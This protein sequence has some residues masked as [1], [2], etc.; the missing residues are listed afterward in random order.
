MSSAADTF[1][2]FVD[3]LIASLDDHAVSG[4]ELAARAHLS[5]FHFDRIVSAV[6]GE[7]PAALRRRILLERAAYRL[8]T[9]GDDVLPVA[10][11]AG[12]AS[13]EAFTRA[14]SRAYGT[15]PSRWRRTPGRFQL[16][17][18][19]T[20]HFDPPG[21]LRVPTQRKVTAMDVLTRMVE[22]HVWMVG[23][24]LSR[25]ERLGDARLDEP[26]TISVEG[27]DDDPTARRLLS[28]LVGQ[29]EMWDA[30]IHGRRYDF[31]VESDESVASMR[32]RL[33]QAGPAFLADVRS[34]V[35]EG[36]LDD[37]FI[38]ATCEPPETFTYAGMIAHVL[39]FGA[40]RRTLVCGVLADAGMGDLGAGDPMH[41]VAEHV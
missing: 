25:A 12:Y 29:L 23:E 4:R 11:E 7:P 28:R 20:V 13:H 27:I 14:F 35:E 40:H 17:P 33:A 41:W 32:A 36:R 26:V 6:A 8:L 2:R 39:T 3:L 34:I 15:S 21:R 19:S 18:A 22:H 1:A 38:D 5:R 31:A 37:T 24:L 16:G 10:L 30:S 9:T